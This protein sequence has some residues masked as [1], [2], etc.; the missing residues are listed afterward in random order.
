MAG[1]YE[2]H[3]YRSCKA[4]VSVKGELTGA[5]LDEIQNMFVRDLPREQARS[6]I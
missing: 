1:D 2:N 4:V 6:L 3:V 5:E